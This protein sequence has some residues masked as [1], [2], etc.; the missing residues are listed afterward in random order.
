MAADTYTPAAAPVVGSAPDPGVLP[1]ADLV[2]RIRSV[3]S[4]CEWMDGPENAENEQFFRSALHHIEAAAKREIEARAETWE[5]AADLADQMGDECGDRAGAL[6]LRSLA[7]GLRGQ[8]DTDLTI[9][10]AKAAAEGA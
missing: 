7:C 6:A 3:I 9:R 5:A 4:A 10:R 1:L 2:A 8:R